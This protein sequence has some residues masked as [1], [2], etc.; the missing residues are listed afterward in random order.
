V[1]LEIE[2]V[3]D[4]ARAC[5]AMLVGAV[6]GGADVV[7]T[8]GSTP[9]QAYHYLATALRD[10]SLDSSDARLWFSDE[11]CVAPDDELSNYKLVKENLLDGLGGLPQPEVRRI[12]GELGPDPAAEAYERQLAEAGE[13]RFEIVLLGLGP[14]THI[15]SLFP[16]QEALNE[17][18]RLAVGVPEAGH[19]P[20]V[21]RVTLTLPVL[22]NADRIVF[23]VTG[24]D[25]AEAVARAF[26][27]QSEPDPGVPA[28]MLVPMAEEIT[29]LLDPA[30]ASRL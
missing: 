13:P 14:D 20:Y 27:P 2:T 30:A 17:R 3:E 28:S 29:V 26:G 12:Q 22:A 4:P 8:G 10:M 6:V 9:R 11:R 1:S 7:L 16:G 21:P 19:E 15:A 18:S 24:Q 25:K 23:L 5:S